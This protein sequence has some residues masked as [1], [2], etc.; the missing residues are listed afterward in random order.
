MKERC[1]V[2]NP[3]EVAMYTWQNPVGKRELVWT[4]GG[5]TFNDELVKVQ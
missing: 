2:L 4:C 5:K 3:G 1:S